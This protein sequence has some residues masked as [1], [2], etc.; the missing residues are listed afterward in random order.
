MSEEKSKAELLKEKLF[1]K[2]EHTSAVIGEKGNAEADSF[3]EGY[4]SYLDASK[5]E[6]ESVETALEMAKAG[7]FTEKG[8]AIEVID[9]KTYK[10]HSNGILI[11]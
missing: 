9:G 1:I 2:K 5:T 6:R 8:Y 10:F 3:S 4:M 11:A 7:G